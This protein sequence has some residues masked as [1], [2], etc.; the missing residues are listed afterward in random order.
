MTPPSRKLRAVVDQ[1]EP[2]APGVVSR[3]AGMEA[4]LL[5]Y[6]GF[7]PAHRSRIWSNNPVERLNR[8]LKRR[9]DVVGI[10]PDTASVIRLVGA[11]L[12]EIND[13]MIA[14]DR[15]YIAAASVAEIDG[16]QPEPQSLPTASRAQRQPTENRTVLLLLILLLHHHPGRVSASAT[17]SEP[18]PTRSQLSTRARS[19]SVAVVPVGTRWSMPTPGVAPRRHRGEGI[20]VPSIDAF[21]GCEIAMAMDSRCDAGD[22][23]RPHD[24]MP[25]IPR[26]RHTW[27]RAKGRRQSRCG[28]GVGRLRPAAGC[29]PSK[30]NPPPR[31]ADRPPSGSRPIRPD[32]RAAQCHTTT[33]SSWSCAAGSWPSGP[34]LTSTSIGVASPSRWNVAVITS[35]GTSKVTTALSWLFGWSCSSAS[36]ALY[37]R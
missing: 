25:T 32:G 13:E 31:A 1:L 4:D 28:V 36:S 11:I 7:P 34:M 21:L 37:G 17:V 35:S 3:L 26:C 18:A 29:E 15:R 8:E 24:P 14:A 12:V 16:I 30:T 33:Y 22:R 20:E 27:A 19:V 5:A 2:T 9:T 6:T 23:S 10:F